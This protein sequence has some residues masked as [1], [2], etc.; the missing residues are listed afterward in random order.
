M[1]TQIKY[2]GFWKRFLAHLI[3]QLILG[4]ARL[5]LFIPIWF[6]VLVGYFSQ[7]NIEEFNSFTKVS[8]QMLDDEMSI[9]VMS[10]FIFVIIGFIMINITADW[11]YYALMES[12]KKQATLGK[13]IVGIKVTDMMGNRIGFGKATG[14]YFGKI[15]SGLILGIGYVMAAF[16][17]KKQ[18]LH[19]ILSNC[20]VVD[21]FSLIN[22]ENT[23]G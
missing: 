6:F 23:S 7:Q 18:A 22:I 11:L 5:I 1:N 17:E 16:T 3:D 19:D 8:Y 14:R 2:A 20:L 10:I 9:A 15:L 12:S 13:M 4:F 21:S